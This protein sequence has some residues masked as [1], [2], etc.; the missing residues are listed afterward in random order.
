MSLVA[1]LEVSEKIV[2]DDEKI[3][4]S[5]FHKDNLKKIG[6]FTIFI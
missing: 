6:V 1:Q 2:V 5:E 4:A 3:T